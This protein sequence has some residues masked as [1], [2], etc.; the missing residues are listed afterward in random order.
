MLTLEFFLEVLANYRPESRETPVPSVVI[1]S[2]EAT[3]GALFVALRGE[4]VDGHDYVA[5]AF[6][7]GAVA[8]LVERPVAGEYPLIDTRQSLSGTPLSGTPVATPLCLLVDDSLVALQQVAGAW[9]A[10]HNI[11]IAGVTGS[12]GKTTTKELIHAVLSR[13]FHTLKSESSYNNEIGLPLTL[14]QI[15]LEHERAI[16]E[17]GTYGR[18]EIAHLCSLARPHIGI[19][20]IIGP[21]HLERMHS[22]DNIVAAKQELVES[23][24]ANGTAILNKDDERVMSMAAHTQAQIFTYGLESSA[25]LWADNIR[26]MGLEGIQFSLHHR[27]E[28]LQNV[29][30]PLLGRHS[31]HTAL[32]AA[33]V[34]LVEGLSWEEILTGLQSITAQLRLVAVPGPQGSIVIDDTYNSSPESA[35]A[36]LNLLH[37]LNGR[38]LAVLGDML[39]L[40]ALE[41]GAHRLV[42]RRAR[43]VADV[44]LAVGR[45]GRLI[46]EEALLTG[47]AEEKVY[48]LDDVETAVATLEKIIQPGDIILIKASRGARL[49][50]VVSAISK[51]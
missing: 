32:R 15:R 39:E 25:D 40:G 44:L 51:G 31:V 9:R 38:R 23:L 1:D 5:D 42:G 21:V 43:V 20:T 46:G 26:S 50:R 2:R 18:G 19:L 41:E 24:P 13:R 47:M 8:A 11:R 12:V 36:A 29:T 16:L 33:A 48:L 37:D 30:V 7:R 3:S 34:G 17:M 4:K 14:L 22:L 6:A 45:L 10:R 27:G 35:I 28:T 49:D